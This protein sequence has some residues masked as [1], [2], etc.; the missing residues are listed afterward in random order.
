MV[1][2]IAEAFKDPN[3]SELLKKWTAVF[4]SDESEGWKR[5]PECEGPYSLWA[6]QRLPWFCLKDR[7]GRNALTKPPTAAVF[8]NEMNAVRLLRE[9]NTNDAL[10]AQARRDRE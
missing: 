8:T 6:N 2:G 9:W 7:N 4:Y 1:G 10:V 5:N 3:D